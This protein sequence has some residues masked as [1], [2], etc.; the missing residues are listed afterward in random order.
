MADSEPLN[1]SMSDTAAR[2]GVGRRELYPVWLLLL[3]EQVLA[4]AAWVVIA[5][6]TLWLM[7]VVPQI[8]VDI[9]WPPN[10]IAYG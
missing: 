6:L 5:R 4:A 9:L 3:G 2:L 10:A 8:P 7:P 1:L